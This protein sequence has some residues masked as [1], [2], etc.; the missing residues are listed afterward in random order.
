VRQQNAGG[1]PQRNRD[2]ACASETHKPHGKRHDQA[3][4]KQ[5]LPLFTPKMR[6]KCVLLC[7]SDM[8]DIWA[9]TARWLDSLNGVTSLALLRT[10]M[11]LDFSVHFISCESAA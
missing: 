4:D 1:L 8:D 5:T 7:G 9:L 6:A 10:A 11:K 3:A 2:G